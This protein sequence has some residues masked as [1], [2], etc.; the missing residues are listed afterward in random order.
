MKSFPAYYLK[1]FEATSLIPFGKV[2]TYG[3]IATY[4]DLGSPRMVGWALKQVTNFVDFEVPAHRVVNSQG[5]LTGMKSFN[6]PDLMIALLKEE[7]IFVKD[8]QVVGLKQYMFDF[9]V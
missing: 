3:R 5:V 7:G 1:V 9:D 2:S 6:P 8:N 4:C